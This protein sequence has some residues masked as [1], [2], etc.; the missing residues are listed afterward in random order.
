[1][2]DDS[3]R[4]KMI[5]E[6]KTEGPVAK[7][8]QYVSTKASQLADKFGFTQEEEYKNKTKEELAKKPSPEPAKKAKGG[9]VKS[10]DGIAKR[11]KTRAK[12]K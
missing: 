2:A 5:K 3:T 8:V 4:T 9:R 11:G 7:A 10:I 12:Q 1:M 6:A